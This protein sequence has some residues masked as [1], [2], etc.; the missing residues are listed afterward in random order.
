MGRSFTDRCRVALPD[1][2]LRSALIIQRDALRN[3]SRK[4]VS[5]NSMPYSVLG[6]RNTNTDKINEKTLAPV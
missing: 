1:A 3:S 5:I 6:N 2:L 4:A